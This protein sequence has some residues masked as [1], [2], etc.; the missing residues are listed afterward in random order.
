[1]IRRPPRSTLF[2]YTTLFRSPLLARDAAH[3][4]HLSSLWAH[5]GVARRLLRAASGLGKTRLYRAS[6]AERR[7]P[8]RRRAGSL[9]ARL[10]GGRNPRARRHGDAG[11]LAA[12]GP[13]AQHAPRRL[14]AKR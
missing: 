4:S 6:G 13:H 2:P 3:D 9:V 7:D 1:M 10:G 14:A 11:V 8:D 12:A 5:R